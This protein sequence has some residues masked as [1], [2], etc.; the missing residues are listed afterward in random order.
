M[1]YFAFPHVEALRF[2]MYFV[3]KSQS[4]TTGLTRK[5]ERKSELSKREKEEIAFLFFTQQ[6]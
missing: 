6:G 2:R 3:E 5:K 1:H 4:K